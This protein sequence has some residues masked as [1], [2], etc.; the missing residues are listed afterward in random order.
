MDPQPQPLVPPGTEAPLSF[1]LPSPPPPQ[2]EPSVSLISLPSH[3]PQ[4]LPLLLPLLPE[5]AAAAA[6]DDEIP[7]PPPSP[8]LSTP[9]QFAVDAATEELESQTRVRFN[10]DHCSP[11]PVCEGHPYSTTQHLFSHTQRKYMYPCPA[12]RCSV[13]CPTLWRL[14]DHALYGHSIRLVRS[15]FRAVNGVCPVDECKRM[16]TSVRGLVQHFLTSHAIVAGMCKRV[17]CR[18]CGAPDLS[19]VEWM[20]H[21]SMHAACATMNNNKEK[22]GIADSNPYWINPALQQRQSVEALIPKEPAAALAN[23]GSRRPIS[24]KASSPPTPTPRLLPSSLPKEPQ[25]PSES[26]K[27]T[28]AAEG[29]TAAAK[30]VRLPSPP[31]PAGAVLLTVE[32]TKKRHREHPLQ[33]PPSNAAATATTKDATLEIPKEQQQQ[34]PRPT[35][36]AKLQ[37]T[38]EER[39]LLHSSNGMKG[40]RPFIKYAV[41]LSGLPKHEILTTRVDELTMAID[42]IHVVSKRILSAD[43]VSITSEQASLMIQYI[44]V[45]D[46]ASAQFS[47]C[48]DACCESIRNAIKTCLK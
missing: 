1:Q 25:I 9:Q 19:I 38:D 41:N 27:P 15:G 48:S 5:A 4:A 22:L 42:N 33:P 10:R 7:S 30:E 39:Q 12:K 2:K 11:C 37:L 35:K 16:C 45:L 34:Q 23:R 20:E 17:T 28:A 14:R 3:P 8:S 31:R 21:T 6:A 24:K 40:V 26:K 44:K 32:G 13:S 46:H 18:A 29:P 43:Q 47:Q 36:E